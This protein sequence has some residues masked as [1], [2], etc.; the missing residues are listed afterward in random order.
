MTSDATSSLGPDGLFNADDFAELVALARALYPHAGLA[1]GP[2]ERTVQKIS[3][4]A[5]REPAFLHIL[6]DGLKEL[7]AG[8]G[9]NIA[10]LAG[11]ALHSLLVQRQGTQFFN[12]LQ[13]SASF[14]LYD[15][16]E[17]WEA[18]G[19]PGASFDQGGYLHRGF[20]DLAW[21]PEPRIEESTVRLVP[22][23]PLPV[24]CATDAATPVRSIA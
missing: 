23:G 2:Y 3:A 9:Q 6:H 18:I 4:R 17:V 15:D 11:D 22:I 5:S 24:A 21:L 19:Y 16:R 14:H 10:T 7:R 20:N 13:T 8:A 12:A 1:D